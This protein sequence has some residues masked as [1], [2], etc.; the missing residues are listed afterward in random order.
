[1]PIEYKISGKDTGINN[2]DAIQPIENGEAANES[3]FQRPSENLRTRTEAI[4]KAIDDLTLTALSDR[5]LNVVCEPDTKI[6]WNSTAGGK[7][8]LNTTGVY[9]D[10]NTRDLK[11]APFMSKAFAASDVA[12]PAVYQ[13][14]KNSGT[15]KFHVTSNSGLHAYDGAN[16]LF[17]E[18]ITGA[19]I[20]RAHV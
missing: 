8:V 15:E 1:M 20:G 19:E 14:S 4:R 10:G 18:M 5:S 2:A 7:F 13:Y 12:D 3:T 16:N 11:I 9:G 6:V 17:F